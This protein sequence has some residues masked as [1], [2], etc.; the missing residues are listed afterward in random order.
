MLEHGGL[1]RRAAQRYGISLER[2]IDLSTG[3]NPHGWP[4]SAVPAE[5]WLR[6]PETGDGLEAAA[7][8]YYGA[9][10]LLAV[11]GTQAAIQALPRLRPPG[12]VAVLE[13]GYDEH[14]RAW[15]AAGHAVIGVCANRLRAGLPAV[16]VLVLANPN[17]P[18]G[19]R[20]DRDELTRWREELAARGGWLVVDEAFMDATPGES[21]APATGAPGLVL[22]R[23]VGKFF[24]LAGIRV[25]F[26]LAAPALLARL[27]EAMG[28]WA[29]ANVSR[30]VAASALAD[31]PWQR[32]MRRLLLLESARLAGLLAGA[33]LRPDGGTALFQWV[34]TP[35]AALA[36]DFLA[37][38]GILTRLFAAPPALR[39]GLP[40][41]AEQWERL[42]G[43]LNEWE[44]SM[45]SP[46]R[47]M[48]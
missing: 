16:D 15:Q 41:G 46:E 38:R 43:A 29:V 13:P 48:G 4:V 30:Y 39:F 6:L 22:L 47:A 26:V 44:R 31:I 10:S 17:N 2:W 12:R 27:E 23:S 14:R 42:A 18:T 28:P 11:P 7:G 40:A 45:R 8:A 33:N 20:F 1:L 36:H 24:G 9:S 34:K 32:E 25:G 35:H 5:R 37:R 19:E 21:L 3:I